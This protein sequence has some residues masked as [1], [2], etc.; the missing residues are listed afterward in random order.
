MEKGCEVS[1]GGFWM[2]VARVE[3]LEL[4]ELDDAM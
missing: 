2:V 1:V 3:E 4:E